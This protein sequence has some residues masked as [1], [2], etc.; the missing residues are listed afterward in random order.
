M[1]KSIF[2]V[3][4]LLGFS[5][6][7]KV[8]KNDLTYSFYSWEN[9]FSLENTK[10]K[11]YIKILDI[12]YSNKLEVIK[13][14]FKSK[15]KNFIPV[16][17]ISNKA[18][19]NAFLNEL[20]QK[21]KTDLKSLPFEFDEIQFDCDWSL[22]SKAKYFSFLKKIKEQFN[23]KLSATIRLH[24]IKYFYKTG[25]PPIDYGVLMYYNMS[26][27]A[28]YDT[29][30]SILDNKIAKRYHYNF[31]IYPL[32][33]KL[34]LPLYTQAIQFRDKKA[35]DIFEGVQN[36]DFINN[37]KKIKTNYYEVTKSFYFRGKY[38]YKGDIFR[39]EEASLDSLKIA[40]KEFFSLSKDSFKEVIFYTIK[41]KNKYDLKK[42]LK[43]SI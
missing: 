8:Q 7:F 14:S 19:K 4:I 42:L 31:D 9:S 27:V 13:T 37:F 24:Q 20:L 29:N 22:N 43:D 21:V 33:L 23:K 40:L 10:E 38:V 30:N 5:L 16:I 11:L 32:K 6:F 41:Y 3:L 39:F 18:M 17:Y 1:K 12:D 25:V 15:P 28:D 2:F 36:K 34:T 26:K 35:L